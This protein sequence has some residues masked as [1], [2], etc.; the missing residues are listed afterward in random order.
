MVVHHQRG[1]HAKL[2]QHASFVAALACHGVYHGDVAIYQ[3]AQILVATGD[4]DAHALRSGQFCQRADNVIGLN[5]FDSQHRKTQ[6]LHHLVNGLN[7][8]AQIIGHGWALRLVLR[9]NGIAKG[10][11]FGI[12]HAGSP[13]GGVIFGERLHHVNHDAQSACGLLAAIG[14]RHAPVAARMV[15]AI[16]VAGAVNQQQGGLGGVCG[17][18][19]IVWHGLHC[20][21]KC[22][23][24]ALE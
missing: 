23:G 6:Q 7:L 1:R 11:A 13:S 2:G 17:G 22:G 3:L 16:Q 12:K 8:A 15:G 24:D 20:A 9:V 19:N 4:D 21:F 10:L 14:Q 18:C 5:A